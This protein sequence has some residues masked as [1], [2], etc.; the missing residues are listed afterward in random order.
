MPS[1]VF[2]VERNDECVCGSGKKY[3]KCCLPKVE[4][5][6]SSLMKAIEG[7]GGVTAEGREFL[8]IISIMYGIDLDMDESEADTERLSRIILQA[9][10][11]EEQIL[12]GSTEE[13]MEAVEKI[14]RD[15][16]EM[17]SV[18]IP[19]F[20]LVD[21]DTDADDDEMEDI[22]N[23]IVDSLSIEEYLID[24][25]YSLRTGEYTDEEIK[26]VFHWISLGLLAGFARGF[27]LP[28]LHVSLR[29]IDEAQEKL[30]KI[31]DGK[32]E[33]NQ[34]E[35]D[36]LS[37]INAEYP[38]F[39]EYMGARAMRDVQDDL[40]DIMDGELSFRFP[41]YTIYAFYL[42]F[43]AATVKMFGDV[44]KGNVLDNS[45]NILN[46]FSDAADEFLQEDVIFEKVYDCIYNTLAEAEKNTDDETLKAK[47]SKVL[48]FFSF[49]T[50]EQFFAIKTI[51]LN[52]LYGY[53]SS[54]PQPADDSGITVKSIDDLSNPEFFEQ[55]VS[56]LESRG[57][58]KEV[59]YIKELYGEMENKT[60]PDVLNSIFSRKNEV[61]G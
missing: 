23:E 37:R 3:K 34:D 12:T 27:M 58:K 48:D 31:F 18:R 26:I 30:E 10:E 40:N 59:D 14:L 13:F 16:P 54:L 47:L 55:Y 22:M 41:F 28:I 9:W 51:F 50:Y 45:D 1:E 24:V 49:F 29:E 2:N 61:K 52:S 11:E 35:M 20:L 38:V 53:F 25:A 7:E 42:K 15:K 36:E 6:Q 43:F 17:K 5:I 60:V 46:Y 56:Y 21:M 8:R 33:L 4:K 44:I 57:L 19:G 39:A 32:D